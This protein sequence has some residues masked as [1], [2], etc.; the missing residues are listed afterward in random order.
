MGRVSVPVSARHR[1]SPGAG[2]P[3]R[4]FPGGKSGPFA[5]GSRDG[6][7]IEFESE[8]RAEVP[9]ITPEGLFSQAHRPV[10][11]AGRVLELSDA[12]MAD[13]ALCFLNVRSR[14]VRL[15]APDGAAIRVEMEDF[16]HVA[17]WSRPGAPFLSIES[18]TGHGDPHDFAGD[19]GEKPSMRSL[20]PGAMARH[21]IRWCYEAAR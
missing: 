14:W 4:C 8:E 7:R 3:D 15:I 20:P 18:W 17:L 2:K 11:L 16:P 12:L 19:I 10:P 13:E 1:L 9:V 5:A 21:E 6:Y